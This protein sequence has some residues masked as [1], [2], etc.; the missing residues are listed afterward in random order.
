MS[1]QHY[2]ALILGS[3]QSG[4]PL[5][6]HLKSLGLSTCLVE[7]SH[8]GGCCVNE[9]CTPT[10]TMV[11]SG[12]VAYLARRGADYGVYLRGNGEDEV[13]VDMQKVRER[14]RA[15]V[16]S[17][18]EGSERRLRAAGVEVLEGEGR[19]MGDKEV[20]V[21]L[22]GGGEN[23]LTADKIF[24]N[25]GCRPSRPAD[26]KGLHTI[27]QSRVLDSTSI[28]E[29]DEVPE[30][31][32]VLGGGYV[33]LEF[34]QLFRRL[35]AKVTVIHR[36]A[37]LFS[38]R[39]DPELVECMQDILKEDGIDIFL[40]ATG[41]TVSTHDD[42]KLPILLS[43]RTP[44]N[45]DAKAV[46][47]SHILLATGRIP[48]TDSLGLE[49]TGIKTTPSGHII[50]SFTLATNVRDVYAM[51]DVRGGPAFTHVSYDD[52]R[53]IRDNP[54][55][56]GTKTEGNVKTTLERTL[57][58]PS[59]VYTDPQLAH[60]GPKLG[61]LPKG[62]EVHTY[63]MPGT[64]IARGLETDETRGM[65]KAVVEPESGRI[66][67]FS[68]ISPEG[69]ELMAVVQMAMVGGIKWKQLQDMVFAHP[70]WSESLNNLWGGEMREFTI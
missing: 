51:G 20:V 55:I 14:K 15:I 41:T 61:D 29:L 6:S 32:V 19:F 57:F 52:F 40:N 43:S 45:D 30:H 25:V 3:G 38:K 5:A 22:N 63:S 67:S 2:N 68:A 48:N 18:R 50:A 64:W 7:R 16:K 26:I 9:G 56:S 31:L 44:S 47:A 4:T 35:G 23:H 10:K 13:K 33:G 66:V 53:I 69:G 24:I 37:R 58:I 60:I 49:N 12:R 8:I 54:F 59:V 34:G 36:G 21:R 46:R 17:F 1:S 27:D 39:D 11:A 70:S 28:Q 65:L 42:P 62:M